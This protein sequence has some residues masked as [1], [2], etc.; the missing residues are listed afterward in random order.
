M[1]GTY[2]TVIYDFPIVFLG[3]E[4]FAQI[5]EAAEIVESANLIPGLAG[6]PGGGVRVRVVQSNAPS[7][8][9]TPLFLVYLPLR[10]KHI[11]T[12]QEREEK[13]GK[14]HTLLICIIMKV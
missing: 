6:Q 14:Y 11:H 13:L 12:Q 10:P 4:H 9:E 7:Q 8:Q 2:R 1:K 5:R 3:K